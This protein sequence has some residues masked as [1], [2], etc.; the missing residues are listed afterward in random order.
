MAKIN[1]IFITGNE[2]KRRE[3]SEILGDQF[4]VINIKLDLPEIQ[5]ISVEEVIAEKIKY[6]LKMSKTKKIFAE[7]KDKFSAMGIT[8]N[9]I[10]DINIICE[11]SGFYIKQMNNFPGALIKWYY[12]AV[13]NEGIIKQNKNSEAE[14][15]CV[16]GLVQNGRI[17]KPIIG[18]RMG[19]VAAIMKGGGG[20]GW[21]PSFIPDLKNTEYAAHNG[22]SYAELSSN[23]KN[24][25]SHRWDAFDKLK[26]NI[27]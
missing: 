26:K 10:K 19:K 24:L 2:G 16:I 4:N 3:V 13:N 6:A 17:K 12:E 20:F 18:S 11:D 22:K 23:I 15:K 1:I 9:S 5:S 27:K 14:T 21:D 8:I 7:I 25:I